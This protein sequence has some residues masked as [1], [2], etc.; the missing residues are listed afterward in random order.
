MATVVGDEPLSIGQLGLEERKTEGIVRPVGSLNGI[1]VV[2]VTS[3]VGAIRTDGRARVRRT[4]IASSQ[5]SQSARSTVGIVEAWRNSQQRV[6]C[7]LIGDMQMLVPEE[8]EQLVLDQRSREGSACSV[9]VQLRI[10]VGEGN[11]AIVFEE[12]RRSVDPIRAAATVE[13]AV[14]R[15]AAGAGAHVDVC[16]A[17]R[18]LLRV[19]H[20]RVDAN[21]LQG[22]RRRRRNRVADG[23][24]DRNGTLLHAGA[25]SAG[26]RR[27]A[28]V[29]DDS[30]RLNLAGALAVEEIARVD[31]VN[32]KRIRRV[33]LAV[34]PNRRITQTA[35]R[36]RAARKFGV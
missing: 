26:T 33:A 15:I 19:I 18:P 27:T 12:E 36:A 4:P 31:T 14:N 5:V 3:G 9:T 29:I 13:A 10:P 8:A 17:G 28:S 2:A 16:A 34:G 7:L 22:L 6:A 1:A 24:I 35:V 25:G 32:K 30:L 11:S 21:F 23:E 20:G